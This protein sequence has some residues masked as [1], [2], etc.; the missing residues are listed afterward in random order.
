MADGETEWSTVSGWRAGTPPSPAA[1]RS[2]GTAETSYGGGAGSLTRAGFREPPEILLHG[3]LVKGRYRIER[4]LGFGGM[5]QVYLAYDEVDCRKVA[6]KVPYDARGG[7]ALESLYRWRNDPR[8][9]KRMVE[10]I[11]GWMGLYHRHI[12]EVF[13]VVDDHETDYVPAVFMEYCEGGGLAGLLRRTDPAPTWPELL[14][15]AVQVCWAMQYA[16]A[17]GLIHLD[18]KP[19]NVLLSADGVAKVSDFGLARALGDE[20]F[21]GDSFRGASLIEISQAAGSP[22]YMAPELWRNEVGQASDIYAFGAMLYEMLTGQC[23]FVGRSLEQVRQMHAECQ[24]TDPLELA[25]QLP[26]RLR[27]AVLACLRKSPGD[28]PGSFGQLAKELIK[29]YR[30]LKH[31]R[32]GRARPSVIKITRDQRR[33]RARSLVRLGDGCRSRGDLEDAIKQYLTAQQA[34]EDAGDGARVA[35]CLGRQASVQW[36]RGREEK[37]MALLKQMARICRDSGDL[38][39]RSSYLGIR[40]SILKDCGQLDKAMARLKAQERICRELDDLFEL[41]LCLNSQAMIV[42]VSGKPEEATGLLK[43]Q[44]RICLTLGDQVGYSDCLGSQAMVL[45]D[46]G[47]PTEEAMKLLK[48]QEVI[49]RRLHY[50]KGFASSLGNQAMLLESKGRLE[51]AMELL[52][53]QEGICREMGD[54]AGLSGSLGR[55][56]E[57][58][59]KQGQLEAASALLEEQDSILHGLGDRTGRL[60]RN[61]QLVVLPIWGERQ[62][63]MALR[64]E[65]E[66]PR[67]ELGGR[68]GRPD[69]LSSQVMTPS[70]WLKQ[71]LTLLERLGRANLGSREKAELMVRLYEQAMFLRNS[72]HAGMSLELLRREEQLR[73]VTDEHRL[74]GV[75]WPTPGLVS[76]LIDYCERNQDIALRLVFPCRPNGELWLGRID[77]I[78]IYASDRQTDWQ[79]TLLPVLEYWARHL[80]VGRIEVYSEGDLNGALEV[81][82]RTFGVLFHN[83]PL[84]QQNFSS[85]LDYLS[86]FLDSDEDSEGNG[87]QTPAR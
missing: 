86:S 43:E 75:L 13:D 56:A 23:P 63:G 37:A 82:I 65:P 24:P 55:R 53:W 60:S 71:A 41:A 45:Y 80:G 46:W 36:V 73:G 77:S 29:C 38:V 22:P 50:R 68:S 74:V 57:C 83:G 72:G 44:E 27:K 85:I 5:G 19:G 87:I 40:A 6:V 35:A 84:T 32:Y 54:R 16:H 69:S 61:E 10:E 20:G 15:V 7:D 62:R 28:R 52:R 14:D 47:W 34:F 17:A 25:P 8:A 18:L 33:W 79:T 66:E 70:G 31:G 49:C 42:R 78:I 4:R 39:R 26:S 81:A 59:G 30:Q 9:R 76:Q 51:E 3:R 48:E 12:V 11:H 67:R 2:T 58:L 1:P 21:R 64:K